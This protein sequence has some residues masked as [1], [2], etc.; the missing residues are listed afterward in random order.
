VFQ[1]ADAEPFDIPLMSDEALRMGPKGRLTKSIHF[2]MLVD[3]LDCRD[4]RSAIAARHWTRSS[5]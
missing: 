1:S 4:E 2:A 3:L 5:A